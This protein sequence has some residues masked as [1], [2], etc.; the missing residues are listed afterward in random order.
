MAEDVRVTFFPILVLLRINFYYDYLLIYLV[1]LNKT[2]I[3]A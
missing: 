2:G 3:F 1:F